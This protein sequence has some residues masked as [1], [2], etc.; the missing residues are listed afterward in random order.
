MEK[1][2]NEIKKRELENK[3]QSDAQFEQ[4][5]KKEA[6]RKKKLEKRRQDDRRRTQEIISIVTAPQGALQ[7]APQI[8]QGSEEP[9]ASATISNTNNAKKIASTSFTK[10]I[11]ATS[12]VNETIEENKLQTNEQT[13]ATASIA[14]NA[15]T[16]AIKSR[17]DRNRTRSIRDKYKL[18]LRLPEPTIKGFALTHLKFLINILMY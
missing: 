7:T 1:T 10:N 6:E 11:E 13:V 8:Y 16:T 5:K 14:A 3:Q 2:L 17:K 12:F 15:T 9:H 4:E 18:P